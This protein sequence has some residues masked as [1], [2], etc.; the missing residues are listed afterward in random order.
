MQAKNNLAFSQVVFCLEEMVGNQFTF[1][2]LF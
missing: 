2:I 1:L